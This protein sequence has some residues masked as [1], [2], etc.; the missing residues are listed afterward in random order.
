VPTGTTE[1]YETLRQRVVQPDGRI[2]HAE[3]RGVLIRCGLARWAQVQVT[4][5]TERLHPD[6]HPGSASSQPEVPLGLEVELV[7]L[8]AGLILSIR[9]ERMRA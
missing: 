1:A 8:V 4:S 6:S 9:Q 7:K 2:E 5:T 3:G